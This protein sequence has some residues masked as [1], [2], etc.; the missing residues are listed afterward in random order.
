MRDS[1][2]TS[3]T[4]VEAPLTDT[5]KRVS[6][7]QPW[8]PPGKPVR[9]A[10]Y[11]IPGG[12][13][14]IG[15]HLRSV[16]GTTEPALIN[17]ELPVARPHPA[18]TGHDLAPWP[19]YHLISST[20]RASYLAWLASGRRDAR[21]PIGL[22]LLF[23]FGLERR[24]L[25]DAGNDPAVARELPAI[26]AEVR[27]LRALHGAGNPSFHTCASS[28]L[29]ALELLTAPRAR[30]PAV[31]EAEP[32]VT[33]RIGS[34]VTVA[35]PP[36]PGGERS[37][38]P[39]TLR[40]GLAGFAVDGLPVPA[41]WARSWTWYHPALVP[42]TPQ[43]RCAQE[44]DRLFALRYTQRFG[45]GLVPRSTGAPLEI[46]YEP[47]SPGLTGVGLNRTDLPD[48]LK[49]PAATRE[50]GVLVD[51]V[52]GALDPY[53][54]WLGKTPSGRGSLAATALLPAELLNRDSGPL[55][56]LLSWAN[57]HLDGRS[58]AVID[59]AE[60]SAFWS[61]AS[62]ERM[63]KDE[64]ATLALVLSRV[65]LGVEPDVRFGGPALAPGPA[66][67]F[68]LDDDAP[69]GP[70]SGYLAATTMLH[71]AA[72]VVPAA[73]DSIVDQS[74]AELATIV[75][76]TSAEGSRLRA[77][78]RWLLAAGVTA[79]GLGRR[80]AALDPAERAATGH[81]LIAVAAAARNVPPAAVIA[82]T[83]AYRMLGL[84]TDLVIHRLHQ[85]SVTG[86]SLARRQPPAEEPVVVRR[87]GP[88][89]P[90]HA[91]PWAGRP[92]R[93]AAEEGSASATPVKAAPTKVPTPGG[94]LLSQD[95]ITRKIAE[96]EAVSTLL[97]AIFTDDEP[98]AQTQAATDPGGAWYLDQAHSDLLRELATRASWARVDFAEVAARHGVL[99]DGALDLLNEA[100]MDIA[101]E[102]VCE[103]D[104]NLSVNRHVLQELL[105]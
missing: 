34:R 65:D 61:T 92:F 27:R 101:G 66:V 68:R 36:A 64:A 53:S 67:L 87:A 59:A 85:W 81:F 96:T 22:V 52:T 97:A 35:V 26:A 73:D 79:T 55:G 95:T 9:V 93:S 23:F 47:A 104:E 15:R 2:T 19:S 46:W 4:F 5:V 86:R 56:H 83:R 54:R 7:Q 103:G 39:M 40:V 44:F 80:I 58:S 12:M 76:L 28:F 57:A 42:R 37:P 82:L 33:A 72:S 60:F 70:S 1:A 31:N 13:I 32:N 94:V 84:D 63:A 49:E 45:T 6:W 17:P 98:I 43:T 14:Y 74:V 77:R 48:V 102:P 18:T 69:D 20:E 105:R 91:L 78:L 8:I 50:L 41:D 25:H 29:D 62:P 51:S 16:L 75:R 24:V 10:G 89:K 30:Q 21:A 71:L 3:T 11:A 99:P 100:A 88:A 38:V 90:G